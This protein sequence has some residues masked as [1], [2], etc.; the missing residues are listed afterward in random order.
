MCRRTETPLIPAC[1]TLIN[2]P[3][4]P[5]RAARLLDRVKPIRPPGDQGHFL[6]RTYLAGYAIVRIGRGSPTP[7]MPARYVAGA[8]S[9]SIDGVGVLGRRSV[10]ALR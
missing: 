6:A 9:Q 7:T 5:H 10:V 1:S 3:T 2:H 8:L 4:S